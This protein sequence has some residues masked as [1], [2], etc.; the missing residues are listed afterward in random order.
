MLPKVVPFF[1]IKEGLFLDSG[2]KR[3]GLLTEK[4]ERQTC[5][6]NTVLECIFDSILFGVCIVGWD[7]R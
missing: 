5:L 6:R 2:L 7:E 3:K 4:R 1:L